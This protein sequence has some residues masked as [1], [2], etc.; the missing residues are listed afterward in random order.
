MGVVDE[1]TIES[2]WMQSEV[3]EVKR[4]GGPCEIL[5]YPISVAERGDVRW[6]PGEEAKKQQAV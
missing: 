5:F 3:R 6:D 2:D 4:G 1:L